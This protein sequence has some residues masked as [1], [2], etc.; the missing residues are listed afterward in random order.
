MFAGRKVKVNP[1]TG[2][3]GVG[4]GSKAVGRHLINS[5]YFIVEKIKEALFYWKGFR[6]SHELF[7]L[8]KND[9]FKSFLIIYNQNAKDLYVV[10]KK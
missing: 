2:E 3:G 4:V 5:P 1:G 6:Q 8:F 7:R 10:F 9:K